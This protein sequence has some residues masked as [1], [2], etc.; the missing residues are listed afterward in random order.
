MAHTI[1]T[2]NP[3]L[4]EATRVTELVGLGDGRYERDG[5]KGSCP[6]LSASL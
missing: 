2:T 5:Q 3:S 4:A 6:Q 1:T